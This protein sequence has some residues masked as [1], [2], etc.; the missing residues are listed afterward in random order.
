[1]ADARSMERSVDLKQG[2]LSKLVGF[3]EK[4]YHD[5]LGKVEALF[6]QNAAA[7]RARSNSHL[8]HE[9]EVEM[10]DEEEDDDEER[11][12]S[13]SEDSEVVEL[14]AGEDVPRLERCVEEVEEDQVDGS[15]DEVLEDKS[16]VRTLDALSVYSKHGRLV[17]LS[18]LLENPKHLFRNEH[19]TAFGTLL[20]PL[21]ED[22]RDDD[23]DNPNP[24]DRELVRQLILTKEQ[25]QPKATTTKAARS[26]AAGIK[27]PTYNPN[28]S[29]AEAF[30]EAR[31]LKDSTALP[32]QIGT[33]QVF[34]LGE[35][36]TSGANAKNYHTSNH[37]FPVGYRSNRLYTS[38]Q[39]PKAKV[40]YTSEILEGPQGPVFRVTHEGGFPIFE[41]ASSSA[42]WLQVLRA[43][44]EKKVSL[45]MQAKGTAISGPEMMGFANKR[46]AAVLEGI[47][48]ALK[49]EGYVFRAQR[50]GNV[51]SGGGGASGRKR[52]KS[53][54]KEGEHGSGKSRSKPK[55]KKSKTK[56]SVD[57]RGAGRK[58]SLLNTLKKGSADLEIM[59]KEEAAAILKTL[60]ALAPYT[61]D[62][63]ALFDTGIGKL[64]N[65]LRK[66]QDSQVSSQAKVLKTKWKEANQGDE[67][68][69]TGAQEKEEIRRHAERLASFVGFAGEAVPEGMTAHAAPTAPRQ[70]LLLRLQRLNTEIPFVSLDAV[71]DSLVGKRVNKLRKHLDPAVAKLAKKLKAKWKQQIEEEGDGVGERASAGRDP[72]PTSPGD[73]SVKSPKAAKGEKQHGGEHSSGSESDEKSK[74]KAKKKKSK[75]KHKHK[76]RSTDG[77]TLAEAERDFNQDVLIKAYKSRKRQ[78]VCLRDIR[79]ISITYG[80]SHATLWL[81]TSKAR[82]RIAGHR[83]GL[84]PSHR[85]YKAFTQLWDSFQAAALTVLVLKHI[86]DAASATY[87]DVLRAILSNAVHCPR[88]GTVEGALPD[89]TSLDKDKVIGSFE[90]IL[91]QATR[92]HSSR[93][94]VL[95]RFM[96]TPFMDNLINIA[97][98]KYESAIK[99]RIESQRKLLRLRTMSEEE[100]QKE[101]K[102]R[103][104]Q[105]QRMVESGN[106]LP[107]DLEIVEDDEAISKGAEPRYHLP[108][109]P[110]GPRPMPIFF[111]CDW[112]SQDLSALAAALGKW[113][114]T[115]HGSAADGT[116]ADVPNPPE[117]QV[118]PVQKFPPAEADL[119][120]FATTHSDELSE[121]RRQVS[122]NFSS[123]LS[124]WLT[125]RHCRSLLP[126]SLSPLLEDFFDFRKTL[127]LAQVAPLCEGLLHLLLSEEPGQNGS[128]TS[129]PASFTGVSTRRSGLSAKAL[130]GVGQ[131]DRTPAYVYNGDELWPPPVRLLSGL[132]WTEVCRRAM[133]QEVMQEVQRMGAREVQRVHGVALR[134]L[135][136]APDLLSR[137]DS[138]LTRLMENPLATPFCVPVDP[139]NHNAPNYLEIIQRPMDLGTVQTRLRSGHYDVAN[140]PDGVRYDERIVVGGVDAEDEEEE[141]DAEEED[142]EEEEEDAGGE[143]KKSAKTAAMEQKK[144]EREMRKAKELARDEVYYKHDCK[145]G[146]H[147]GFAADVRQVWRNC[148][149]FNNYRTKIY[150][151]SWKLKNQFAKM[152]QSQVLAFAYVHAPE[153]NAAGSSAVNAKAT[154]VDENAVGQL[155]VKLR[156]AVDVS[157]LPFSLTLDVLHWLVAKVLETSAARSLVQKNADLMRQIEREEL[158]RLQVRLAVA[159]NLF[160]L[161][162]F[163]RAVCRIGMCNKA[164]LLTLQGL[165]TACSM[166]DVTCPRN[167]WKVM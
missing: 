79:A 166:L 165:Y 160:I 16:I 18:K 40:T 35:L 158:K 3:A 7:S 103:K 80:P 82:Y 19:I 137:C 4:T 157:A 24:S 100:K 134:D 9:D 91:D 104:E 150:Q 44:N 159:R 8:D 94:R 29:R 36:V 62:F 161:Q 81:E 139:I 114:G 53:A 69:E 118:H 93:K 51:G 89:E 149:T 109:N 127:L 155:M 121:R 167:I 132:T 66:H 115:V 117:L 88:P 128:S 2:F 131:E 148:E 23:A 101:A 129:A 30:E 14:E 54:E 122:S 20:S 87:D 126:A 37:L 112:A 45:G 26:N 135:R 102:R 49:C 5:E 52:K 125:L 98:E 31:K 136:A 162:L 72:N 32:L 56:E 22:L 90:A 141:E 105:M 38:V 83:L 43:V 124:L 17:L 138:L 107:D 47:D 58:E 50:Q 116:S 34:A 41:A 120:T 63:S 78:R 25:A 67:P 85:Y 146:G 68:V 163:R 108:K 106:N 143:R 86:D 15:F 42:V 48:G 33:V 39:D 92:M 144:A 12:G 164:Y 133:L 156:E 57:G 65:R 55:S 28:V 153:T 151:D 59:A 60:Q 75:K 97:K 13:D 21:P 111:D 74:K 64:V 76:R 11:S 10:R 123:L 96:N 113:Y 70:R 27:L 73:E 77:S 147:E 130:G 99:K 71:V 140:R 61:V 145:G 119:L 152:Y 46:I 84:V 142:A 154:K 110:C 1:M 95:K 6:I